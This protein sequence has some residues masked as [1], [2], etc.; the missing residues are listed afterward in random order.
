M[1][2]TATHI[3]HVTS[4]HRRYDVRIFIKEA[5]SLARA[6][7][8]VSLIVADDQPNE[9]N[10]GVDIYSIGAFSTRRQRLLYGR[11]SIYRQIRLLAPT[12]VHIHDPELLLL[13]R[14]LYSS[15]IA[16]IYDA[17][18]D[19]PKQVLDKHWLPK[20]LRKPISAIVARYETRI[21][22]KTLQAVI[23]ATPH[24]AVRFKQHA[25]TVV[26][27][28]YPVITA[29]T[30]LNDWQQRHEC[31]CYVGSISLSRGILPLLHAATIYDL[32]LTLAGIIG[33]DSKGH[34]SKLLQR[35]NNIC[36]KGVLTH[37]DTLQLLTTAK[38]G[39]ITLMPTASYLESLP[40]KLFEY[41]LCGLPIVAS[42]FPL[43]RAIIDKYN[44]GI[45]V[46]PCNCYAIA[47]ACNYLLTHQE[48]AMLMGRNGFIAVQ[49][50][51]NWQQEEVKL[52]DLYKRIIATSV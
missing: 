3:C 47:K 18:E 17:H 25:T 30:T 40:I 37:R 24:I 13:A 10:S 7:Y 42:D 33:D 31:I 34:V 14:K 28:N 45:L 35:G 4:V 19:V 26:V 20:I 2:N 43:W 6:N 11:T 23:A 8:R 29:S 21:A 38:V 36:Y 51:L 15:G 44:C 52:L 16:I 1:A 12:I 48:E 50:E 46:D 32:P 41:M 39:I 27:R 49:Q 5:S 22:A 9:T